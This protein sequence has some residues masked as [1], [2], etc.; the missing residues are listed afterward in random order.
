MNAASELAVS[1]WRWAGAL[2]VAGLFAFLIGAGLWKPA[3]FEISVPEGLRVMSRYRGRLQWLT[4]WMMCGILLST[5]GVAALQ[6][7][8]AQWGQHRSAFT[9]PFFIGAPLG[10][11][12]LVLLRAAILNT[13]L[14]ADVELSAGLLRTRQLAGLCYVGHMLLWY[15]GWVALGR[16]GLTT[17]IFPPWYGWLAIVL[18]TVY[19]LGFMVMRGGFFAPPF[20]VHLVPAIG[21][22]VLLVRPP[23]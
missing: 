15:A 21:G 6:T 11:A 8:L 10:I 20:W 2:M 17:Q 12:F 16:L 19:F 4:G 23:S 1:E 18:G 14:E 5:L 3:E 22:V 13:P 9:M 7:T